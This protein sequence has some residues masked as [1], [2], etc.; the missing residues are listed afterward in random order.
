MLTRLIAAALLVLMGSAV[1]GAQ[2]Q[3]TDA[4]WPNRPLRFVVPFPAGSVTDIASRIVANKLS[5]RLGQPV[6]I[7]N[8]VGASGAV[9]A[10]AIAHAAPDGYT[11]GLITA[12]TNAIAPSLS[13]SLPYD[14]VKDFTMISLVGEAPYVLVVTNKLPAK[15]VAELIALAKA[16]PKALNYSTVGPASLASFAGALFQS[17]TQVQ[18]TQVPYRSA[19]YAVVDLNEGR[20]EMQFGAIGASLPHVRD[21]KLRALAVT[22]KTRVPA[23]PDVPTME[24]AGLPGYEAV[25]WMAVVAPAGL[26]TMMS[27]R[28]QKEMQT[29]VA[30]PDVRKALEDQVVQ[31]K[32]STPKELSDRITREVA[33]WRTIAAQAGIKAQ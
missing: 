19:T 25:L 18:L 2:P 12:S 21:G 24:E 5:E 17:M 32:S 7:E 30:A 8:R 16:K 3:A 10:D 22:S 31:P 6:V 1:A 11:I 33:L 9:G 29:V 4:S 14:P 27:E 23:L 28:L 13:T 15:N 26:P 20:I